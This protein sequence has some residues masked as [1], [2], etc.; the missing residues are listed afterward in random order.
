MGLVYIMSSFNIIHIETLIEWIEFIRFQR[1]MTSLSKNTIIHNIKR[2][3]KKAKAH[4]CKTKEAGCGRF[5]SSSGV[6]RGLREKLISCPVHLFCFP[7]PAKRVQ[8]GRNCLGRDQ[9]GISWGGLDVKIIPKY[10]FT[11]WN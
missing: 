11:C 9:M 10:P 8:S 5:V 4:S 1:K 7:I 2:E 6:C 3:P